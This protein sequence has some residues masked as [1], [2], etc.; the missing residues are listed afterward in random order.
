MCFL[1][2]EVYWKLG[3]LPR[4]RTE[5]R[6]TALLRSHALDSVTIKTFKTV[7][8]RAE[9][10]YGALQIMFIF[11]IIVIIIIICSAAISY[12]FLKILFLTISVRPIISNSARPIFT[13]FG[14]LI[15]L[16]LLVI[17]EKLVFLIPQ[18]TATNFYWFHPQNWVLIHRSA[19]S[20]LPVT[21]GR[22][23]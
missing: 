12:L 18:Q 23:S 20:L 21:F 2:L 4:L 3:K 13:K 16:W 14:G 1:L 19:K 8:L 22:R 10:A 7:K 17:N 6:P 11:I 5:V 15:E 9:R